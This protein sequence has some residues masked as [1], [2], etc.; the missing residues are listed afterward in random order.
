MNLYRQ[1]KR[2]EEIYWPI[3]SYCTS[4][5][6]PVTTIAHHKAPLHLCCLIPMSQTQSSHWH[7]TTHIQ[8]ATSITPG[9][10]RS[11]PCLYLPLSNAHDEAEFTSLCHLSAPYEANAVDGTQLHSREASF[12]LAQ[13]LFPTYCSLQ[14]NAFGLDIIAFS[15][16]AVLNITQSLPQSSSGRFSTFTAS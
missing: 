14:T 13:P 4:L 3:S 10:Q 1:E 6:Q 5:P 11:A 12:E 8:I 16:T 7:R 9:Q 15:F 2:R